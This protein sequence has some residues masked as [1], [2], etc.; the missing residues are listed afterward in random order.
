MMHDIN[1]ECGGDGDDDGDDDN[2]QPIDCETETERKGKILPGA[3]PDTGKRV[4]DRF[5]PGLR[6]FL[7]EGFPG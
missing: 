4:Q 6:V 5:I 2:V 3:R 1:S 7:Q